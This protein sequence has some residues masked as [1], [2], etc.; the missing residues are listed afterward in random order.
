MKRIQ[1][2]IT[3]LCISLVIGCSSEEV[4]GTGSSNPKKEIPTKVEEMIAQGP[5]KYAGDNYDKEKVEEELDKIDS[6]ATQE[7]DIV[8]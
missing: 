3:V 6:E 1:T 4:K 5:G 2:L 8:Q 7:E